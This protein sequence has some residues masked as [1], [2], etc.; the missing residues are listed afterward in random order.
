MVN[1]GF[2]PD[3]PPLPLSSRKIMIDEWEYNRLN[4][5]NVQMFSINSCKAACNFIV[6]NISQ[7]VGLRWITKV[8]VEVILLFDEKLNFV[9]SD[10]AFQV[11]QA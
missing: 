6:Q 3:Q 10:M 8:N 4:C 11:W 2:S 9:V 7:I 5:I 1:E